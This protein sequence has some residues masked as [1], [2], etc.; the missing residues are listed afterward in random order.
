MKRLY[1]GTLLT[2]LYQARSGNKVTNDLLCQQIFEAYAVDFSHCGS[3][4]D[5]LKIGH[6]NPPSYLKNAAE[7][8]TFEEADIVFQNKVVPIIKEVKKESLIRAIKSILDGDGE[9]SDYKV[10]GYIKGYEKENIVKHPTVSFSAI[11][12]SVFYYV[13]TDNSIGDCSDAI[14]EIPKVYVDSFDNFDI[15][16]YFEKSDAERVVPLDRSLRDPM[17]NRTFEKVSDLEITGVAN[18]S[19]AQ[20]YTVDMMNSKLRFKNAKEFLSDN[21]SSYVMSCE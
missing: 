11:L 1:F 20:I 16:V 14:K 17:F 9:I 8:L 21:L 4:S 5:H 18:H 6:D 3:T 7:K 2:I 13:L 12:A 10:V 19:T 15:P